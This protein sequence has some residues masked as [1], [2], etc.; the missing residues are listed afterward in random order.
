MLSILSIEGAGQEV[1]KLIP[2]SFNSEYDEYC[3]Q[4]FDIGFAFC[5]NRRIDFF[6]QSLDGDYNPNSNI[7]YIRGK[8]KE[9]SELAEV[10]NSVENEGPF[11]FSPDQ[12]RIYF[13]GTVLST[14]KNVG[15][16]LGI[17]YS[18]YKNAV[19]GKPVSL[20]IN[21]DDGTFHVAHPGISSDGKTLFF[22]SD[23]QG[24]FGGKD[25]YAYEI[26]EDDI[27]VPYNLG[28]SVNSDQDEITPFM[29]RGNL[30]Y[31]S[32]NST[33]NLDFDIFCVNYSKSDI[34]QKNR[35][36]EPINSEYDD[37]A[38]WL[39]ETS[40][41]GTLSSFRNGL[42]CDVFLLSDFISGIY[43]PK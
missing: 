37:L 43:S 25:I 33:E 20:P 10:L 24:G 30:L 2:A 13:T 23:M 21:S 6:K 1:C 39:D 40:K 35:L 38:F 7:L 36:P 17:Y 16:W 27:S 19:W 14:R 22:S 5:S 31:F 3:A 12:T 15:N 29:G 18:D 8:I 42:N 9:T 41:I 32:T 26:K 11:S 4:D 28:A 34:G